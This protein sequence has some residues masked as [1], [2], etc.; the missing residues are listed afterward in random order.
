[1]PA[2][3]DEL[4]AGAEVVDEARSSTSAIDGPPATAMR[5][6]ERGQRAA[7]VERAVDRVDHHPVGRRAVAEDHLAALLRDRRE[8]GAGVVQ[9]SRARRR[10]SRSASRSMTSERSPPSPTPRVLGPGA[11]R[12]GARVELGLRADDPPAGVEPDLGGESRVL[13]SGHRGHARHGVRC[14]RTATQPT[15]AQRARRRAR[16]GPAAGP[17]RRRLGPHRGAGAAARGA[18]RRR[19]PAR[20]TYSSSPARAPPAARLRERAEALLDRPH[21]E[22]WIH[23]YEEAAEAL[24][25]EYSTEAGL[26]PFFTTVGPGRPARD[27]ARPARRSAAAPPRDSRQPGRAA[28]APAAPH[29]PA[30]GRGGRA[31]GAARVG[32]RRASAPR[33]TPPSASAPSARSSSPTSTPATTASCARPA[34]STAA[35]WCSS[36][37]SCC[38]TA[39]TSPTRSARRFP[40]RARRRARGRRDRPPRACS[41]RSAPTATSSAPCDPDQATRR[42]RGAGRAALEAFRAAHPGAAEIELGG[43]AANP[44]RD[45]VLALRERPR[46]GPGGRPRGRAPARRGRGARRADLRDRR[47]GLA[48]GTAGRRG[49]RGAQRPVPLRRRRGLL[50]A[51]GGPRRARLAADARRPRRRRRGRPHAHQAAGRPALG[52]PGE[53]DDDRPAA[54]AR[55]DLGARGGA[56]E[57]AAAARGARP[58]PDLP[59]PAPRR[60]RTRS[61]GCAPTSSSAG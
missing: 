11:D 9:A 17:R 14:P 15:D 27:P 57:P 28:G 41:R 5:E 48:R 20:S 59:A 53:G 58:D 39:P 43:V 3:G 21:E 19:G 29:R 44:G 26:D 36:S 8:P 49:A 22:L 6:R 1:M 52:R 40:Q 46:A 38:A 54:Q 37:A 47:L 34:A 35:T 13:R 50:P 16:R 2:L 32:G 33:P 12:A 30:Q 56:R 51:A 31:V 45:P 23:T 42:F 10:R 61:S 4:L 24:L 25:R 60:R 18:R 7:G 55:H